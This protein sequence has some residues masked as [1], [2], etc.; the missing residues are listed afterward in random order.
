MQQ[1]ADAVWWA[2]LLV[3]ISCLGI[4]MCFAT[5]LL[6]EQNTSFVTFQVGRNVIWAK[7][8]SLAA[9][10]A[11]VSTISGAI[12]VENIAKLNLKRKF[13]YC[14][15]FG[16]TYRWGYNK[17][18]S[19]MYRSS[20]SGVDYLHRH[21]ETGRSSGW[22]PGRH[23]RHWRQGSTSRVTI[24]AVVLPTFP[25]LC[26]EVGSFRTFTCFRDR[27]YFL[28]LGSSYTVLPLPPESLHTVHVF[29]CISKLGH[30]II[31]FEKSSFK[32]KAL[33]F[34][35]NDMPAV[36][37]LATVTVCRNGVFCGVLGSGHQRNIAGFLFPPGASG[38]AAARIEHAF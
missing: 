2:L 7:F 21:T 23:S 34:R 12:S 9:A 11:L 1:I 5:L 4:I 30:Q 36:L 33:L 25:F 10:E 35:Y 24:M 31:S 22:L 29:R 19:G 3:I 17:K 16:W 14:T 20:N 37:T 26:R 8:S 13:V 38:S 6:Y 32:N 18:Y 28:I 15:D 27:Y